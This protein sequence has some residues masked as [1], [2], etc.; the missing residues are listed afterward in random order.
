MHAKGT[1]VGHY[2][3]L[4]VVVVSLPLLGLTAGTIWR[5]QQAQRRQHEVTLLGVAR[6]AAQSIDRGFDRVEIGLRALAVSS[7]LQ[8]RDL[9]DFTHEIVLMSARLGDMPISL[10]GRD[11]RPVIQVPP[12]GTTLAADVYAASRGSEPVVTNLVAGSNSASRAVAVVV[13]VTGGDDVMR[14]YVLVAAIDTNRLI[15]MADPP[16]SA[17]LV[18]AI[19]DRSGVTAARSLQSESHI[20][21]PARPEFMAAVSGRQSGL[22]ADTAPLDGKPAIHAFSLTGASGY[23]VSVAVPESAFGAGIRRDLLNTVLIGAG[24][25]LLGVFAAVYLGRRLVAALHVLEHGDTASIPPSGLREVD[26]LAVRL[27]AVAGE[28]DTKETTLRMSEERLRDLVGTLDLA[29]IMVRELKGAIRFWSHGCARMYGWTVDEAVGRVSHDLLRT[30]FP[31][32][33]VR[34]EQT[35]LAV[36]EWKGDLIHHHRDGRRIVVA[37][38]KALK[39]DPDGLPHMVME[40]LVDVTALREA[41]DALGRLNQNLEQ[42]VRTEV[43]ARETAQHRAAHADRVRALG[44]LAGGIAHDFNNVL[45]AVAGGAALIARRPGD[46]DCVGRMVHIISDAA[47]RGASITR[48]MLLLARRGDLQAEPVEAASLLDGIREVF[49][50][51]LGAAIDVR[52]DVAPRLPALFADKAQLETALVNLGTNARDAMPDGGILTLSAALDVVTGD[53]GPHIAGLQQSVYVRLT[54]TDDGTGMSS[55]TLARLGEPFFTT[56]EVGKGTGLGLSMVK[57]FADQSGGGFAVESQQGSGTTVTLWLPGASGDQRQPSGANTE[58]DTRARTAARILL[59][60]DDPLVRDTLI[61][62][63]EELG[64][65]VLVASGGTDAL[66]I[67][68]AREAVDLMITD[69]SMP[70]MNGLTLIRE[71]RDLHPNLP[72]ILL[73]GHSGDSMSLEGAGVSPGSYSLLRKPATS[74]VLAARVTALLERL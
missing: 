9:D 53:A 56:K 19:R 33:L 40:S 38:H 70:G 22:L 44:Q 4:L 60:D 13:P 64:H 10:I 1:R 49:V 16:N 41:Q 11:G 65:K 51:T 42:R 71:A 24:L 45:Q 74:A 32:P 63:L 25:L 67:L 8:R 55:A 12:D 39:R 20:G 5:A 57:G 18:I 66:A 15:Q 72:A 21:E 3:V 48:R 52:V 2:L 61:E 14:S 73:T 29:A 59:V 31:V 17:G 46:A 6:E 58:L 69:L 54:V 23:I 35:L 50:H 27:K 37:A 28:R 26:E 43:A 30:E 7:A 34:I 47:A 68:Q 36:G 62:Q